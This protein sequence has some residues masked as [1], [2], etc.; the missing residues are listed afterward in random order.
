MFHGDFRNIAWAGF[1]VLVILVVWF[2]F[3]EFLKSIKRN[4][5]E[6][7]HGIVKEVIRGSLTVYI[8]C[9]LSDK[10]GTFG[11]LMQ[12][13]S[14]IGAGC[15]CALVLPVILYFLIFRNMELITA[16]KGKVIG[17]HQEEPAVVVKIVQP[18][19]QT[20]STP[21]EKAEG[22]GEQS[23]NDDKKP[24]DISSNEKQKILDIV[25]QNQDNK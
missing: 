24:V 14:W 17:K 2:Y 8:V 1:F 10:C 12:S 6:I 23:N 16:L 4:F 11:C 3:E 5:I 13:F 21:E 20:E 22:D 9:S 15:F 18:E 19:A 25:D 7:V